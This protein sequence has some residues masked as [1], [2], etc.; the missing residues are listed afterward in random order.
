MDFR[1]VSSSFDSL[2]AGDN[3]E[4]HY[5]HGVNTS[6]NSS[7]KDM[8]TDKVIN[9]RIWRIAVSMY[10]TLPSYCTTKAVH[11][12]ARTRHDLRALDD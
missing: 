8:I 9:H 4:R 12:P 6:M 7:T 11:S 5:K 3:A 2:T 10:V 1:D